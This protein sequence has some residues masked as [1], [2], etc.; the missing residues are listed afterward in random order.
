MK[1]IELK[2]LIREV[3]E[4]SKNNVEEMARTID[5]NS[6]ASK[7][8]AYVKENPDAKASE[9][10]TALGIDRNSVSVQLNKMRKS[11]DV[12]TGA[13]PRKQKEIPGVDYIPEDKLYFVIDED[14][15][16]LIETMQDLF[17]RLGTD[18]LSDEQ[19]VDLYYEAKHL[20][21]KNFKTDH[22]S[23]VRRTED[24]LYNAAW[25]NNEYQRLLTH[26]LEW[27]LPDE[28]EKE[29]RAY[30]KNSISES[31]KY[32][33]RDIQE[34]VEQAS[35]DAQYQVETHIEKSDDDFE[36]PWAVKE[37]SPEDIADSEDLA[38]SMIKWYERY[39][40]SKSK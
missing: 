29:I 15:N 26:F 28:I 14:V 27:D 23:N 39:E 8:L 1:R 2:Q 10:A 6:K 12:V 37:G 30:F 31:N 34:I 19:F 21:L 4:E 33:E 18:I 25:Y 22:P 20:S 40:A 3:I 5:P 13:R 11:G 32:K 35:A 36:I 24:T 38:R 7:I 16:K 9:I 17:F